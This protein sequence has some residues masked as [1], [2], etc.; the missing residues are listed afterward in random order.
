MRSMSSWAPSPNTPRPT[1]G[2]A[3]SS[4]WGSCTRSKA[5]ATVPSVADA[6]LSALVP[7][8]ARADAAL[9]SLHDPSR[10]DAG[11]L[12]RPDS[13]RGDRH[14]WDRVAPPHARRPQPPADR[15]ERPLESP[16]DRR[17][18]TV[19]LIESVGVGRGVGVCRRQCRG[20]YLSMA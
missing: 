20:Q 15:P 16:L 10:L 7:P 12:G 9:S 2:P 13:T 11:L 6:R 17:R 5:L 4:P 3:R 18:E 14:L 8:L 19:S 1:S